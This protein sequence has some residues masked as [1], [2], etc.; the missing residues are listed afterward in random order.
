MCTINVFIMKGELYYSLDLSQRDRQFF[1]N[2]V[3]YKLGLQNDNL[4]LVLYFKCQHITLKIKI[5]KQMLFL[6]FF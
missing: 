4:A 2:R 6:A 5:N 3:F 1:L